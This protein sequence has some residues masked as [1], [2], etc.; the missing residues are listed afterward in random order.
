MMK[1]EHNHLISRTGKLK[2]AQEESRKFPTMRQVSKG[3]DVTF[4]KALKPDG[5]CLAS[6]P[7]M[8]QWQSYRI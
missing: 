5:Q 7:V 2:T 1:A 3:K 8:G 4:T 6:G